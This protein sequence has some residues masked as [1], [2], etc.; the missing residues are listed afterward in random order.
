M[1]I[2]GLEFPEAVEALARRT[3]FTLRYEE[4]TPRAAGD[5]GAL[6]LVDVTA[7][8]QD[9]FRAQL[10]ADE[11]EVARDYLKER[12]FGREDAER[13]ELGFAPNAWEAMSRALTARRATAEDLIDRPGC[14]CATTAAACATGSAAG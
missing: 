7:A 11:G 2:E 5:R 10:Y 13:F 14:R 3:G 9:F 6:R 12:G 4:L 8:A 1:R